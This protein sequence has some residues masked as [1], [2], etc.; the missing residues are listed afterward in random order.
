MTQVNR[1]INW[2]SADSAFILP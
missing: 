1:V 2:K